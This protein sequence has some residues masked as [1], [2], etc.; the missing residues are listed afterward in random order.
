MFF[1]LKWYGFGILFTVWMNY[2]AG[3]KYLFIMDIVDF[4]L[5][6]IGLFRENGENETIS[7][8]P[9]NSARMEILCSMRSI[10]EFKH[11]VSTAFCHPLHFVI[12]SK[13][14]IHGN[15]FSGLSSLF[16]KFRESVAKFLPQL[17]GNEEYEENHSR[18]H[19]DGSARCQV[20]PV[21]KP[22]AKEDKYRSVHKRK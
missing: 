12:P 4:P 6:E 16:R 13:E 2:D 15:Q 22:Q 1:V 14:G 8:H 21:R 11:R 18:N 5:S 9:E 7:Y 20:E 10:R 3:S 17:S 19:D